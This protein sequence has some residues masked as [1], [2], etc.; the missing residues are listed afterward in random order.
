M[1]IKSYKIKGTYT[2]IVMMSILLFLTY[3]AFAISL[4]EDFI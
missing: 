1:Y 2:M 3:V 4:I